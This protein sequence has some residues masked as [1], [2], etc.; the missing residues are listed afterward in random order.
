MAIREWQNLP[1]MF[2][3]WAARKADR[4][5]LW[6]KQGKDWRSISW[7]EAERTVR[8]LACGLR[9]LGI[10]RGDRVALIAENRPEWVIAD[11]AIMAAGAIS[12]PAY[13]TYTTED[14]RH[15]LANSNVKAMILSSNALGLRVL[16]A[17]D[18]IS[19]LSSIVAL[20][21]LKAQTNAHAYTWE[22]ILAKGAAASEG[23]DAIVASIQPDDVACL[24]YTSGTG[25]VPKGVM[26]SHRNMMSNAG[27]A[28]RV[29]EEAFGL[30]DEV[31]LS[32]LPLTHSY[33]HTAGVVFPLMSGA[34]IYFTQPENLAADMGTVRPTIM[35]AVPRLCETLHRR[36]GTVGR[37]TPQIVP[38]GLAARHQAP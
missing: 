4:P 19:H 5:F 32:F 31:F 35:T 17:A 36:S 22:E 27:G 34:E 14:F 2:F 6:S 23:L 1:L 20:E 13:T 9:A 37:S 16:P 15:V 38:P 24:I 28:K 29:L 30:D 21:P 18:Q 7:A 33:E 10:E 25:G 26:L 3:D 12:V 11:L 8:Q